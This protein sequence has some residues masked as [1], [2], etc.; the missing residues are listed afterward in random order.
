[1]H[2][3]YI[4]ETTIHM[5]I[6][7]KLNCILQAVYYCTYACNTCICNLFNATTLTCGSLAALVV[8]WSITVAAAVTS[9]GTKVLGADVTSTKISDS[10][11]GG[12]YTQNKKCMKLHALHTFYVDT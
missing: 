7:L 3:H 5:Y 12:F 4:C 2:M 6:I 1:M 10:I 11:S 8:S 9:L